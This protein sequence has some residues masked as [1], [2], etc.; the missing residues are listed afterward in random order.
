MTMP[1]TTCTS[2]ALPVATTV[3]GISVMRPPY[4]R[5][6]GIAAMRSLLMVVC[7]RTLCVSTTGVSPV[8]VIV[9]VTA[10]TRISVLT[11]AVKVRVSSIPSRL[12]VLN[13]V[14]LNERA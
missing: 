13:P 3:L 11:T 5:A 9:S 12:K 4:A 6:A 1:G 7:R 14:R 10:P 8:T 2:D